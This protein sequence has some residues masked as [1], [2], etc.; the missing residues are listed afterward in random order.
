M[1]WEVEACPGIGANG[2]YGT[3]LTVEEAIAARGEGYEVAPGGIGDTS[4][5]VDS[6]G[7]V[8]PFPEPNRD[9]RLWWRL[10]RSPEVRGRDGEDHLASSPI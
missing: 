9:D 8:P 2:P 1:V 5:E 4:T 10:P 7:R 3:D 6:G